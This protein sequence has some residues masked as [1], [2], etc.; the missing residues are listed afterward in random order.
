MRDMETNLQRPQ[1]LFAQPVRYEVPAFQRRYVW[2]QDRQWEPL[3]N[4]V[5]NLAESNMEDGRNA[6]AHFMGAVV[7]QHVQFPTGT[8][9]R[10]IV[11]DGQQRL[12]TLQLL[13]DAVQKVL[14]VRGCSDPAKRLSALVDNRQEFRDG[15]KDNAFKVWPTAVDR[16]AFRH[17]MSHDLPGAEHAA[18]RIV[19]AHDYF[20]GQY[21]EF[22]RRF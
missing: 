21:R 22:R 2:N 15:A 19:Q 1:R 20:K 14:E 3:W 8:V 9:E 18:S 17:A 12:T 4:D 5:E 7:L 6:Q 11:V 16:A 10:R 13:I